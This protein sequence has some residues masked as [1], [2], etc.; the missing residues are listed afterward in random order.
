MS[1]AGDKAPYMGVVG[2]PALLLRRMSAFPREAWTQGGKGT[3]AAGK[4][5]VLVARYNPDQL[6]AVEDALGVIRATA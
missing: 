2:M 3:E 1:D 6:R 4:L 5:L